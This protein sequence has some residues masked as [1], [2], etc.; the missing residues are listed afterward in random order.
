MST[1]AAA[2]PSQRLSAL[3]SLRGLAALAVI[4]YHFTDHFSTYC[5][6]A[7]AAPWFD[8]AS[9]ERGVDL[10]FMLSG[11]L[12][13]MTLDRTKSTADFVFGRFSRL[14]PTFLVCALFTFVFARV[15]ALPWCWVSNR[16]AFVNLTM[17]PELLRAEPI[18][19]VYWTL[20]CEILFYGLALLAWRFG[21][22]K[23][24]LFALGAWLACEF[25]MHYLQAAAPEGSLQWKLACWSG[26]LF[27]F[28]YA[29]LFAVGMAIYDVRRSG[30][31]TVAH[32]GVVAA[33]LYLGCTS[34]A[35]PYV[36]P[37]WIVIPLA[38]IFYA[39]V[40]GWL[41]FLNNRA[42]VWLGGISYPLYLIHEVP[43]TTAIHDMDRLGWNPNLAVALA[44]A[45]S[46]L[47]AWPVSRFIEYPAMAALRGVWKKLK[48]RRSVG[49]V[50]VITAPLLPE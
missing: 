50:P 18:D 21:L 11:F 48:T 7:G 27:S 25:V 24:P 22:L 13:F 47:L 29:H 45:G 39:T 35:L 19:H 20:Q 42:L 2:P 37:H 3:D 49:A 14:Y 15:M 17:L 46:I 4:L 31:W 5:S 44:V 28:R 32:A 1:P 12:I 26:T 38:A 36:S 43:G 34:S 6:R 30:R 23:R 16:D 8:F 40:A 41:P 10:F 9:G 33:A